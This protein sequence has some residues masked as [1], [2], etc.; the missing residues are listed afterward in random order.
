MTWLIRIIE[1]SLHP[2]ILD[3]YLD[4]YKENGWCFFN[5]LMN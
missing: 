2:L 5:Q 1:L 3:R 4:S